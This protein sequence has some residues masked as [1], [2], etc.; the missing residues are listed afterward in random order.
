M[1]RFSSFQCSPAESLLVG[2]VVG[3][4]TLG[5]RSWSSLKRKCIL[6]GLRICLRRGRRGRR[7]LCSSGGFGGRSGER[8]LRSWRKLRLF[9]FR[10]GTVG[11]QSPYYGLLLSPVW[12]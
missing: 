3:L 1:C 7:M 4:G 8:M 12:H 5:C 2:G 9:R 6:K 10:L 11:Y